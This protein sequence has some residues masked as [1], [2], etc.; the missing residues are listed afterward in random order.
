MA[1]WLPWVRWRHARLRAQ[2][3]PA[4]WAGIVDEVLAAH[5]LAPEERERLDGLVQIFLDDKDFEGLGGL[6]MT[7]RIRLTIAAHACLL[8]V[9]LDV[10]VPYPGLVAV[11]VYPSDYRLEGHRV[12]RDLAVPVDSHRLGQSGPDSVVLAW[13]AVRQGIAVPDDGINLVFHEF[14][15]Q[16]D[17]QDGS[18]DG[19]PVLPAELYA[20]WARILGAAFEE[21]E[22]D[23]AANRRTVL[24]AYGATDPAEFFAVA[25]ETFFERPR[26]LRHEHPEL[27]AILSGFYQQDPAARRARARSGGG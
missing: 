16:L 18:A 8:L 10:D 21:L 14:A 22:R 27:Y 7:D 19:A 24:D 23:V 2:P 11:R 1:S 6:E 4:A 25:T 15:H 5:P 17:T 9:G 13:S 3:L 20:P 12:V 26:Q